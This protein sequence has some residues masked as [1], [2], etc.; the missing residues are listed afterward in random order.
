MEVPPVQN[1]LP[2]YDVGVIVGRFQV[3]E[4][5][6]AH[7]DLIQHVC[8]QH[9]KVLILLGVSPLPSS[10]SNPLDFESRKQ[11]ILEKFPDVSVLY[12]KDQ[13]S[14]EVW[15]RKVDEIIND[16]GMPG[17]TNVLYGSRDSFIAH[18]T[19]RFPTRELLPERILSGTEVRRQIARSR[20]RATADFRAGVI[21]ATQARFPTSYTTVDVAILNEEG[22]K[23]LLCRKEHEK[24]YRFVGGFADPASETFERDARREVAEETTLEVG[25]LEYIGSLRIDDWRYRAEPDCIKTMLFSARYLFGR[26]EPRDDIVEVRWFDLCDAEGVQKIKASEVA[27]NHRPLLAMLLA[28]YRIGD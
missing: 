28:H 1:A 13:G 6:D 19:G 11:M 25:E 5:H 4:L 8:E 2:Q 22:T 16:F 27:P 20:T 3:H 17:Q 23:V 21:W 9:D 24:L 7:L 15:S 14:D 10:V 12:V 26:P 18:Y